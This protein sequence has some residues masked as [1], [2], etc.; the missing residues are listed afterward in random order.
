MSSREHTSSEDSRDDSDEQRD[1]DSCRQ[2]GC[3][4]P[5]D[6]EEPCLITVLT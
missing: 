2:P 3:Y 4:L 1:D 6:H 5:P